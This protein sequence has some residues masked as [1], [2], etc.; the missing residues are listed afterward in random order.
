MFFHNICASQYLK[1]KALSY[2]FTIFSTYT[3]VGTVFNHKVLEELK[4]AR[5]FGKEAAKRTS[6]YSHVLGFF[7]LSK[8]QS[9]TRLTCQIPMAKKATKYKPITAKDTTGTPSSAALLRKAWLA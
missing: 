1:I 4:G 9:R 6:L 8:N 2:N 5:K 7:M 3:L